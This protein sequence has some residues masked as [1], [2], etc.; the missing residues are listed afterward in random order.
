M[1]RAKFDQMTLATDKGKR[2][3]YMDRFISNTVL[4]KSDT[5]FIKE[6]GAETG[7]FSQRE[8][9]NI[10]FSILGRAIMCFHISIL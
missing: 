10:I 1:K 9:W 2:V 8:D 5:N 7:D 6:R 3:I 4:W